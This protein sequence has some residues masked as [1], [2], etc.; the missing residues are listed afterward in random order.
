[1]DGSSM[2]RHA[3]VTALGG[4]HGSACAYWAGAEQVPG[5]DL[6]VPVRAGVIDVAGGRGALAFA[7]HALHGVPCTVVDPRSVLPSEQYCATRLT[8]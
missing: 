7:L 4:R 1:M 8:L 2:L 5:A 6:S 3:G